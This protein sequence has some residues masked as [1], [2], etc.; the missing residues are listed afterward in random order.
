M[1]DCP[2]IRISCPDI[3]HVGVPVTVTAVVSNF[4]SDSKLAYKWN[5]S[6]GTII[7]GRGTNSIVVDT[8]G[9][10]GEVFTATVEVEGL[11]EGCSRSA[12][13]SIFDYQPRTGDNKIDEYG[14]IRWGDEK[15]RLDNFAI[16]LQ[17]EPKLTGYMIGYGGRQARVGEA[18]KRLER[19]KK[20]LSTVRGI[21][22]E[23]IVVI[24]G[25]Y[26]ESL[27]VEMWLISPGMKPPAASPTVNPN[28]VHIIKASP[29]GRRH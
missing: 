12:S 2:T 22:P 25:G 19:A 7:T 17:M 27:T 29:K 1:C 14:N 16:E 6:E 9:L 15:A 18:L 10:T 28:E 11:P 23:R 13:C 3:L 26:R 20:Y 24:D 21:A 8:A 4:V 5:V